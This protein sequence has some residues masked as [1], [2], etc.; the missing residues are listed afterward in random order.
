MV[1][2]SRHKRK[3]V[4][5]YDSYS[6][7]MIIL[8]YDS[9]DSDLAF[10]IFF[11]SIFFVLS[12]FVMI[13]GA[14]FNSLKIWGISNFL[15]PLFMWVILSLHWKRR[16]KKIIGV[17]R[18]TPHTR[19]YLADA[20]ISDL[21]EINTNLL[22]GVRGTSYLTDRLDAGYLGM[23]TVAIIY[24]IFSETRR[25]EAILG[26]MFCLEFWLILH[27]FRQKW[28]KHKLVKRVKKMLKDKH[29]P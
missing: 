6:D 7:S 2:L 18:K 19:I 17:I 8:P 26:A 29:A 24:A 27:T 3:G 11:V 28:Q 22:L 25:Y 9:L 13:S 10:D 5:C 4:M 16:K 21:K 20:S 14:L 15:F 12:F 1:L 23:A